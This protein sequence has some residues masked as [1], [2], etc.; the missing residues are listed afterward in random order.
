MVFKCVGKS[1]FTSKK[2]G[3]E[4]CVLQLTRAYRDGENGVGEK[5]KEQF[6]SAEDYDKAPVGGEIDIF[7]NEGGFVDS[8]VVRK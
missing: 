2:S 6:V 4:C 8:L 3:K 5:V 7:Y 1:R